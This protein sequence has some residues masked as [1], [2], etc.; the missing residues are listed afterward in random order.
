MAEGG[1]AQPIVKGEERPLIDEVAGTS[2][3]AVIF[4]DKHKLIN[5]E[6]LHHTKKNISLSAYDEQTMKNVRILLITFLTGITNGFEF[7]FVLDIKP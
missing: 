2:L 6:N 3:H 5:C 4:K 1:I 7:T